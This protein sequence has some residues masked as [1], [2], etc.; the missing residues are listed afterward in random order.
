VTLSTATPGAD[1]YYTTNGTTPST[2]STRY[3]G[4]IALSV[5]TTI[6]AIATKT[7][8]TPSTVSIYTYVINSAVAS[9]TANPTSG[10]Y[11]GIQL[12]ALSTVTPGAAIR[13]RITSNTGSW[14]SWQDYTAP[15]TVSRARNIEAF[16][17]KFGLSPSGTVSFQYAI[18]TQ[19]ASPE[20][21]P[22]PGNYNVDNRLKVSLT[23]ATDNATIF[24][25]LDG[26]IPT[27]L[28]GT[29]YDPHNQIR[30]IPTANYTIRAI[31]FIDSAAYVDSAVVS[32]SYYVY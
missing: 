28:N 8:L 29:L 30:L 2:S 19:V 10:S 3:A 26:S 23:S 9:P 6:K 24:Y 25:T 32:F 15:I 21:D 5:D 27:R 18:V 4:A 31:A 12:V 11:T 7:G 17:T 14:G 22:V 13:Y 20:A 16:A 1:I